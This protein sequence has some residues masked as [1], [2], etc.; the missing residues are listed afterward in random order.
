MKISIICVYNNKQTL[1]NCLLDSLKKTKTEYEL[2]L[3]DNRNGEFNS[4]ADALNYGGNK[5]N[6]DL[7]LFVHQD[8]IFFE[9]NLE[10][11][12]FYCKNSQNLGIAGVAGTD[13]LSGLVK[14]N[15][16]HHTPPIDMGPIH[17][18]EVESAQTLDEVLL[19]IPKEV[20]DNFKFD[21]KTCYHWHL[22][23]ADYC[24]QLK[25]K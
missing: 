12:I 11:I 2:I 1:K 24:L 7:L 18:Y 3:I 5:A 15:G 16:I 21:A 25:K 8:V 13:E 17:I 4:A 10:D 23:G 20:F 6:G 14:S 9:N 19:I 22:Y